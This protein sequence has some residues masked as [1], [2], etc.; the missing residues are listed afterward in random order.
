VPFFFNPFWKTVSSYV[1]RRLTFVLCRIII[2]K[3]W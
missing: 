1:S 3:E 2:G